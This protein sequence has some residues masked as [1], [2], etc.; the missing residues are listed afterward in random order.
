[1][2]SW[3]RQEHIRSEADKVQNGRLSRDNHGNGKREME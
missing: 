2:D 1:L 3:V